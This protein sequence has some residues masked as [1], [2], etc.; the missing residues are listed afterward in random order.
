MDDREEFEKRARSE[1]LPLKKSRDGDYE[2]WETQLA[3]A[4]YKI[5]QTEVYA[6]KV[7]F[8]EL[9]EENAMIKDQ[10]TIC[11][12]R[13]EFWQ[14]RYNRLAELYNLEAKETG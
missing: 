10:V 11:R 13:V 14:D 8:G 7:K 1:C 5:S 3:W 2:N 9:K 12:N 6:L 4:G